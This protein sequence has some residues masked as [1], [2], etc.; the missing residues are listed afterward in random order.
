[1]NIVCSDTSL[2][3]EGSVLI[4]PNLNYGYV[5]QTWTVITIPAGKLETVSM[6]LQNAPDSI[7]VAYNLEGDAESGWTITATALPLQTIIMLR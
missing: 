3:L 1:M 2:H 5:G 7:R 4:R 6:S